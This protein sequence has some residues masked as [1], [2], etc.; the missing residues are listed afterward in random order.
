MS[1]G[2]GPRIVRNGLVFCLDAANQKSYPGSGTTW[3]DLISRTTVGTLTNGPTFDSANKGSILMDG[4]D[5]WVSLPSG[6]EG[7][8]IDNSSMEIWIKQTSDKNTEYFKAGTPNIDGVDEC[9]LWYVSGTTTLRFIHFVDPYGSRSF[10]ETTHSINMADSTWHQIVGTFSGNT[11]SGTSSLY[12][13]GELVSSSSSIGNSSTMGAAGLS[14]GN[15]SYAF[16]GNFSI[17][18]LYNKTLSAAE[19]RQNFNALRGR[20]GV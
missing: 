5:Q 9:A 17:A 6:L 19:V 7:L 13:D 1:L 14:L 11:T 8:Y 20:F 12:L 2:H 4:V 15:S 16:G 10:V 3:T 18:K